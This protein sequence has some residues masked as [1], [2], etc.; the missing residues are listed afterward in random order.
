MIDQSQKNGWIV[1]GRESAE[2]KRATL[3]HHATYIVFGQE[4]KGTEEL[5]VLEVKGSGGLEVP[6]VS[7]LHGGLFSLLLETQGPHLL[8]VVVVLRAR[9]TGR[10]SRPARVMGM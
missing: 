4:M 6:A 1:A 10:T 3:A 9:S 5:V 8:L 2:R 7:L